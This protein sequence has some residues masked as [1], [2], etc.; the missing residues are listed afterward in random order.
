MSLQEHRCALPPHILRSLHGNEQAVNGK[1]A[2]TG[3]V[4]AQHQ[5]MDECPLTIRLNYQMNN[6][7]M[8]QDWGHWQMGVALQD[9]ANPVSSHFGRLSGWGAPKHC[10]EISL[11]RETDRH[12]RERQDN[13]GHYECRMLSLYSS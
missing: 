9:Q 5:E 6:V 13:Q 2:K 3:G 11:A 4:T 1:I 10:V 8:T 7:M 12:G